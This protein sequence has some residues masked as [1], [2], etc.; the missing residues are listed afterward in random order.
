MFERLRRVLSASVTAAVIASIAALPGPAEAGPV[1]E[2]LTFLPVADTYVRESAPDAANGSS[3]SLYVDANERKESFLKFDVRGLVGNP[4]TDVR[5]R[6]FQKDTSPVGGRAFLLPDNS[7]TEAMTWNTRPTGYKSAGA[8]D[9]VGQVVKNQWYTFDLGPVVDSGG[10]VS[11]A[12]DSTSSDGSVWASL[13]SATDPVLEVDYQTDDSVVL[14]GLS[15]AAPPTVGSSSPTYYGTNH[16]MVVTEAG[17]LLAVHGRHAT[18]VQLVWRNP[19]GTWNTTTTG[20]VADGMLLK[21]TGTGDWTA[22]IA[23]ADDSS[24]NPHAWVVWAGPTSGTNKAL[25]MRRLSDLDSPNGPSV[26]PLVTIAPTGTSGQTGNSKVDLAFET[27]PSGDQRGVVA[28]LK[29]TGSSSYEIAYTWFTDL[30]SDTPTFHGSGSLI[31]HTSGGLHG[32]LVTTGGGVAWLGRSKTVLRVHQH[33]ASDPLTTWTAG[34]SGLGLGS[35]SFPSAEVLDSGEILAAVESDTAN[36]VVKV[37]RF[38]ASGTASP[39]ELTLSGYA[40]PSVAT[41]GTNAWL[42][43]IRVSDR[44]VVSRQLTAT[45]WTNEDRIEISSVNC[46]T[47]CSWPNA[48]RRTDGRLRLLVQGPAGGPAQN[49]VLAFQRQLS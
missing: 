36:H 47:N 34:N 13:Q 6:L 30:D 9:S 2:T 3:S 46:G 22:S 15:Q 8:L 7:W 38:G 11:F 45:G 27:A 42:I 40:H 19:W 25:Q 24:G 21:G 17:R 10:L 44:A 12:L 1:T 39:V 18:G 5:L 26:G 31:S 14:D 28:W 20:A 16:R 29:R 32:T 49:A 48:V 33:D 4:V 35:Q 43:M 37:Q 41:D 23:M